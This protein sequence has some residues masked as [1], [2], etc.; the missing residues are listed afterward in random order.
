VFDEV[1]N[2]GLLYDRIRSASN[3][4]S[5]DWSL[6]FVDDGSRDGS[7]DLIRS[8]ATRDRRVRMI[9][10]SRNFGQQAALSAGLRYSIGDA[11]VVLDADLQDPPE[12]VG[13]MVELRRAGYEIVHAVRTRR[14]EHA[15]KRIA[16]WSFYR[17]IRAISDVR[18]ALD[19]G[20]FCLM[21]RAVVNALNDCGE[22]NQFIRGL[23]AWVGYRQT[24][25]LYDR[26]ERA[27]GRSKYSPAMLIRLAWSGIIG[28]SDLPIR[29]VFSIGIIST[30]AVICLISATTFRSNF[31][32][33]GDS[34]S[35]SAVVVVWGSVIAL[36]GAIQLCCIGI[37]GR[38]VSLIVDEARGRPSYIIREAVGVDPD[39]G[40]R[41]GWFIVGD[42]FGL[43]VRPTSGD[44]G[45]ATRQFDR[46]ESA[47]LSKGGKA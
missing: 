10:L 19:S 8:L 31:G 18:P 32:W 46:R 5:F 7:A 4:W 43:P 1:D 14:K 21:D 42:R 38:Y 22:R 16:Y 26:P 35:Q 24:E 6:T 30:F 2:I 27:S 28:F 17:L 47:S 11:V 25:L 9:S 45:S 15:L 33:I 40:G 44:P 12:L 20:D 41:V 23:R 13:A 29:M 37:L 3:N 34:N 36:L 39:V